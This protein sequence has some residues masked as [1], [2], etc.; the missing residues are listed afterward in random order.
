M[1]GTA[2]TA[3]EIGRGYLEAL[4][5]QDL[6]RALGFWAD[7]FVDDLVGV[8]VLTTRDE[9]RAIFAGMFGAL[10]DYRLTINSVVSEGDRCHV[11][12]T[13]TGNFDGQGAMLGLK[14][15]GRR[16]EMQGIDMLTVRDGKLVHNTSL[17]N[18]AELARQ[19]G[20]LP[21]LGGRLERAMYGTANVVAPLAKRI[22]ARK[23]GR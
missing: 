1:T 9:V 11:H 18:G 3:A 10:T 6:D 4:A 5:D 7:E 21:P 20:L 8:E 14:P 13:V 12:W 2:P 22:R 17:S 15:N 16:M 23:A 19:L